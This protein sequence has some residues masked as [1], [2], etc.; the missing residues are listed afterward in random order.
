M[1]HGTYTSLPLEFTIL[2]ECWILSK[3]LCYLFFP[4]FHRYF[5]QASL[6]YLVFSQCFDL[7]VSVFGVLLWLCWPGIISYRKKKSETKKKTPKLGWQ[8]G[9]RKKVK[10]SH[11]FRWNM[12]LSSHR[13]T[14]FFFFP[15]ICG[16][17][18][19][20]VIGTMPDK[21]SFP[22]SKKNLVPHFYSW[23]T[24]APSARHEWHPF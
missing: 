7:S 23:M 5:Y 19:G 10:K 4:D 6:V 15:V 12:A 18:E 13:G 9:K 16:A 22:T 2:T 17:L 21:L 1:W 8:T 20:H 3:R 24:R 11:L 14:T